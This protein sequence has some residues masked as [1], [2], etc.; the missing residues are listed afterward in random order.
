MCLVIT[1]VV[2]LIIIPI[3]YQ[4]STEAKVASN[5]LTDI[6]N[7]ESINF[8]DSLKSLPLVGKKVVQLET[9]WNTHRALLLEHVLSYQNQILTVVKL[10][11]KGLGKTLF[12]LFI[13][14]FSAFFLFRYGNE[15]ATR[16]TRACRN[17]GGSTLEHFI[18]LVHGT[19][20]ATVYGVLL[21]SLVQGILAGI[22]FYIVGAPAPVLLGIVTAFLSFIPFGPPFLYV[23]IALYLIFATGSWIW[24]VFLLVWGTALVSTA[25]NILRPLFISQATSMSLLLVL[26]G[27]LGGISAFGLIGVFVGPVVIAICQKI[28]VEF[29][30]ARPESETKAA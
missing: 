3:T 16:L 29:T 7:Q 1:L 21:T 11:A 26:L 24:G 6:Y 17:V 5:Y 27:I 28:W 12:I 30:E 2:L 10:A 18:E 15:L 14:I 23:P 19:I 8:P 22:G 9:E 20:Q 25:D 13:A 4:L